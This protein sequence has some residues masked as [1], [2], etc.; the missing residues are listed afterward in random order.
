M[1]NYGQLAWPLIDYALSILRIATGRSCHKIL[2]DKWFLRAISVRA[3]RRYRPITNSVKRAMTSNKS[4]NITNYCQVSDTAS[5]SIFFSSDNLVTIFATLDSLIVSEA[6]VHCWVL[7]VALT[8]SCKRC[9]GHFGRRTALRISIG[10]LERLINVLCQR[11][12][13][14]DWKLHIA[15]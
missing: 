8:L 15:V 10:D 5:D 3:S 9:W 6:I 1:Y 12:V 7:L 4:L 2:E 14:F 11:L 13:T